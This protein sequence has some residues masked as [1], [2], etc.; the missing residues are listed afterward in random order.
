MLSRSTV[1]YARS[2]YHRSPAVDLRLPTIRVIVGQ[3]LAARLDAL[4]LK[5]IIEEARADSAACNLFLRTRQ[6]VARTAGN[7]LP[8]RAEGRAHVWKWRRARL[9]FDEKRRVAHVSG[10]VAIGGRYLRWPRHTRLFGTLDSV[11][12]VCIAEGY[13]QYILS[14]GSVESA[15]LCRALCA[16]LRT[17]DT[18]H[19]CLFGRIPF[20]IQPRCA[21]C[22]GAY[23]TRHGTDCNARVAFQRLC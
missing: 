5:M 3:W 21:A 10:V 9:G 16:S 15:G 8:G 13:D 12:A 4:L 6:C 23:S 22:L 1:A 14:E 17:E 7:G 18:A 19:N 20:H 2:S 11:R